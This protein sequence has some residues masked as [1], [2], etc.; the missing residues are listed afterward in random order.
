MKHI[1]TRE[2]PSL[3]FKVVEKMRQDPHERTTFESLEDMTGWPPPA[4]LEVIE[5]E[6][7]PSLFFYVLRL[8]SLGSRSG[9]GMVA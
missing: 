7:K 5:R 1:S 3:E 9:L 6:W 8:S 2:K 4:K